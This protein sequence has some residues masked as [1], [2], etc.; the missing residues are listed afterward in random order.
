MGDPSSGCRRS[1][2]AAGRPELPRPRREEPGQYDNE[3]VYELKSVYHTALTSYHFSFE[4]SKYPPT[5]TP[6]T[7]APSQHRSLNSQVC[8]S[9]QFTA[10]SF[11]PVACALASASWDLS[12]LPHPRRASLCSH[13]PV[14]RASWTSKTGSSLAMS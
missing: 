9:S 6:G 11:I 14:L 3:Y 7:L 1:R 12:H 8:R 4:T 5:F 2:H 13:G 10:A